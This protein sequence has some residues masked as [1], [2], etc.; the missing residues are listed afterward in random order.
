[1]IVVA[2]AVALALGAGYWA[3]TR[4]GAPAGG[5]AERGTPAA[6]APGSGRQIL[7]YRNPMGLP[8]TSPVPKK[9]SMGMDYIPVYAD[10]RPTDEGVVAVSP[11][12]VQTLGVKTVLAGLRPLDAALRASGRVEV[13]ERAQVVI[14]PRFEGWIER[15][16]VSAVGDPVR[17][18]QP[19]FTVYSPDLQS[20]GDELRIAERLQRDSAASDPV[21]GEA[22]QRLAEATRARLRNLEVA[23]QGAARQTFHAPADGVVLEKNA[24]QG[25]RFMPG[26]ALFRIADLS[27][28]WVI[29]EVFEHDLGRVEV[30][31]QASVTLDA[32]PGRRFEAKVAYLYPTLNAATRSTPVRLEL[33]NRDGLLRPGMFAQVELAGGG[34]AR[35]T[36]PTSAV[37]DDG[38]RQVV[39]VALG[40]GRFKP[41]AVRLGERGREFVE[42]LEG[43]AEGE[44]VVVS[45]NFLIDSESRLKA[46]LSNLGDAEEAAAERYG[47]AGSFEAYDAAA[48][49]VTLSHGEIPALQWP[50]MTMDFGLAAPGLIEGLA[51]GTPV[52]FEFEQRAPGEF[53]V[54]RIERAEPDGHHGH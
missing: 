34:G 9:D 38:D 46:A 12:R 4:H 39:L 32:F 54:T 10:D 33:D 53:V 50:A 44:R 36:V 26:E 52:R 29:A 23:G 7:Y 25:A 49:S 42:V 15:L 51:P 37:I 28:V 16:H 8:D 1:M 27:R 2:T 43:L 14:A 45:A 17:R 13:D 20:A 21:A 18:G 41:Q 47:A 6:Q 22:A 19:L 3:G 31:Q 30:G 24:V 40:E 11:A 5:E 48:G 35:L